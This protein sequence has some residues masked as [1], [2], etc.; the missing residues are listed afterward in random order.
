MTLKLC[1][2]CGTLPIM[3]ASFGCVSDL[4]WAECDSCKCTGPEADTKE[5]AINLW[6]T[7]FV[8]QEDTR[9]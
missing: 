6:N 3:E 7:R 4:F 9:D 1:P 5:Q 8:Y 2:F